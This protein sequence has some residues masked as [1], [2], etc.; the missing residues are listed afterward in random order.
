MQQQLHKN[1]T[2]C[3]PER[4]EGYHSLIHKFSNFQIL[5]FSIL[6]S[7]FSIQATAQPYQWDWA[8]NGG[9]SMGSGGWNYQV[10]QIFDIAPLFCTLHLYCFLFFLSL[11]YAS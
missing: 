3:Y 4:S 10:E 1:N 9:G 2:P 11:I 5:L 7:L 6:Y 8:L